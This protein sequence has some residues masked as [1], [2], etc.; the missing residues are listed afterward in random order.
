MKK[1]LILA[2]LVGAAAL[3]WNHFGKPGNDA[4]TDLENRLATAERA[5][6]QAGRAAGL[7]GVDTTSD[8]ARARQEV[9]RVES[10]LRDLGRTT[11]SAQDKRRIN[12]LLDRAADLKRR[13]G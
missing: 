10:A 6:H 8:A 4:L 9:A 2:L 1:L 13:M 7:A 11:T 3:A 5:F 12:E